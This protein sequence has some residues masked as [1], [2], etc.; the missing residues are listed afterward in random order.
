MRV[1][2]DICP[3]LM[4][5]QAGNT[6]CRAH[7]LI[8]SAHVQKTACCFGVLKAAIIYEVRRRRRR[9]QTVSAVQN[10]TAHK[11]TMPGLCPDRTM[12]AQGTACCCG[13]LKGAICPVRRRV[14]A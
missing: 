13:I 14:Q 11:S 12:P 7:C 4:R 6:D 2:S 10:T 8:P 3:A 9:G 5:I 1:S